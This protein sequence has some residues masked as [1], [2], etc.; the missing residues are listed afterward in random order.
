ME[1]RGGLC[2]EG[3]QEMQKRQCGG[4]RLVAIS[5][6]GGPASLRGEAGGF[7]YMVCAGAEYKVH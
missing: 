5:S 4:R 6:F 2:T 7:L 3:A 1:G